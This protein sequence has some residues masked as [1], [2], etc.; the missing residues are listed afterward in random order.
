MTHLLLRTADCPQLIISINTSSDVRPEELELMC[1]VVGRS[2]KIHKCRVGL[3]PN[4]PGAKD[5]TNCEC[6]LDCRRDVG[7]EAEVARIRA[8]QHRRAQGIK[9]EAPHD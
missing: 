4:I 6:L 5:T 8:E 2:C 3:P 7:L 1:N 9:W